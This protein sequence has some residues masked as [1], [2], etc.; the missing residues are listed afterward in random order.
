MN[1]NKKLNRIFNSLNINESIREDVKNMYIECESKISFKGRN[2]DVII[3]SFIYIVAKKKNFPIDVK[4]FGN[5]SEVMRNVKFLKEN[6][7]ESVEVVKPNEELYYDA[8]IEAY[9]RRYANILQIERIVIQ[10]ILKHIHKAQYLMR[11]KEIIAASI[12]VLYY[13]DPKMILRIAKIAQ[14]APGAIKSTIEELKVN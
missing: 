1:F 7:N 12:I 11:K 8:D 10:S 4:I 5:D 14:L 3:C 13:D 6:M 9:I 2:M